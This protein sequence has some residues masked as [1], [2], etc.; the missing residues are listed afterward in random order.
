MKIVFLGTGAAVP[1]KNRNP[2]SI[3]IKFN[4]ETFLFD[5]GEGT[6]RQMIYT[7]V[8]PMKIDNI[9]I[10][11]LHGDHILGIPGLLQSMGFN[12][13]KTPINIYGPPETEEIIRIMLNMGYH[14]INFQVNVYEIPIEKPHCILESESYKIYSY[15]MEHSIPTL[16]YVFKEKKKPQLD[17]KRAIEL[18]INVGPDLKKLKE[19]RSVI[20]KDGREIHPVDVLL[21]PKRGISIGYSGD[22]LPLKDF[23]KFLKSLDCNIL[24]HEATFDSSKKENALETMHSTIE[25]AVNIGTI[26][27]VEELILTHISAR[28]DDNMEIYLNE[29]INL[30]REKNLNITIAE[31]L[32]EFPLKGINKNNKK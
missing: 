20:L 8:S 17:I 25:N 30:S 24:I 14:S 21:P 5:C 12:G 31:D 28:Y 10:T 26:A 6:Q 9:F 27:K 29:V 22:T 16:G 19:G 13:R 1:A 3:A 18:G 15:P 32:M 23:G 4:G 11:H 7:D 2:T